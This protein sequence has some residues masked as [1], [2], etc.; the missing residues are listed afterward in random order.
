MQTIINPYLTARYPLRR[1]APKWTHHH[2]NA[3]PEITRINRAGLVPAHNRKESIMTTFDHYAGDSLLHL[4]S[5]LNS[6]AEA[7]IDPAFDAEMEELDRQF[8]ELRLTFD[9]N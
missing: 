3:G 4:T 6:F 9:H 2:Q 5:T 7:G 8:A 1:A